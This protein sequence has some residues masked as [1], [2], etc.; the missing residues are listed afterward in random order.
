MSDHPLDPFECKADGKCEL[1]EM[2]RAVGLE[3][4]RYNHGARTHLALPVR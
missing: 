4:V 2:A 1:H 3:S